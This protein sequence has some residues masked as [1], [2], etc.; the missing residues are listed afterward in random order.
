[1]AMGPGK[2][3]DLCTYVAEQ[4]GVTSRGGAAFVIIINGNKGSGFS[5]VG[6]LLTMTRVPELLESMAKQI[7]EDLEKGKL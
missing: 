1:M 3:D 5:S 4:S 2:Y 7:R 6:D